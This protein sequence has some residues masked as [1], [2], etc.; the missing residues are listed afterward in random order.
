MITVR[1]WA[2]YGMLA[3]IWGALLGWQVAEH[4]RNSKQLHDNLIERCRVKS[5][6]CARLMRAPGFSRSVINK[7]RLEVALNALVDTNELRAVELLNKSD[8]I[9]ASAGA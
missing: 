8:E 4:I 6:T 7:E 2:V 1:S 5:S 9:V 3:A